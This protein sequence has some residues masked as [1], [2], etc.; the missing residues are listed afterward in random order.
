MQKKLIALAVAGA[1]TAPLAAHADAPT[2]YGKIHVSIESISND[3]SAADPDSG[4]ATSTNSSRLGV[5]GSSDLDNGMKLVYQME[6]EVGVGATSKNN[7]MSRNTYVGL[8][9]DFGTILTGRH[10]TPFKGVGR[11]VDYFGDG[12]GDSRT[13]INPDKK[14]Y[15]L[16]PDNVIAY[17]TPEMGGFSAVLAYVTDAA[18]DTKDD[19]KQTAT[20][21]SATYKAGS[22]MLGLGYQS[23]SK[24]ATGGEAETAT[25]LVGSYNFGSFEVSALVQNMT[26]HK[27]I[28]GKDGSAMGI[29]GKLDL[30]AGSDIRAQYYS[31]AAWDDADDTDVSKF[32]IGYFTKLAKKT[33]L[34]VSYASVANGDASSVNLNDNGG[35]GDAGPATTSAGG[36]PNAIGVGLIH[37]F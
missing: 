6:G 15:D 23:L 22:L 31:M 26:A 16:R 8:A 7:F 5:K 25:R 12:M 32:A 19:G 14:Y 24:D 3:N 33:T 30:G 29:G 21:L 18:D 28:D 1:L 20:S 4:L 34:Y 17:A 37:S 11:S 13:V 9:G 2:V 10:D 36:S 35:H 27:G